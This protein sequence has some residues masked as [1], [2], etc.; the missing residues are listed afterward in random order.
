MCLAARQFYSATCAPM[1]PRWTWVPTALSSLCMR[2]CSG[3]LHFGC[4]P[5]C[6]ARSGAGW[7][8]MAAGT[9]SAWYCPSH[10]QALLLK[11]VC[12]GGTLFVSSSFS[13]PSYAVLILILILI[14][15]SISCIFSLWPCRFLQLLTGSQCHCPGLYFRAPTK[16]WGGVW[17][18]P[19]V[20]QT[21]APEC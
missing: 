19:T 12:G 8:R 21:P 14:F 20:H 6:Q 15:I 16:V 3:C 1:H 2:V 11:S 18:M 4:A 13:K 10:L 9:P 5:C 17:H 7:R